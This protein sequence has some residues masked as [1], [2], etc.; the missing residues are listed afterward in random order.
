MKNPLKRLFCERALSKVKNGD[1]SGIAM[2][3]EAMGS[4]MYTLAISI[5]G[6]REDAEDVL[7]ETLLKIQQR[8]SDYDKSKNGYSWVLTMTHNISVDFFRKR[9]K[10]VDIEVLSDTEEL[11]VTYPVD[12]KLIVEDALNKLDRTDREIIVLK[13]FASLKYKEISHLTGL[14]VDAVEKRY[15]RSLK[16]LK[17]YLS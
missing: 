3:Y 15:Q 11:S 8:I 5:L 14:S 16:K 2:L 1:M 10:V 9:K 4:Q 12:D 13:I 6:N 7:Q 17:E